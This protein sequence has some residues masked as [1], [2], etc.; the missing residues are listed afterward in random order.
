MILIEDGVLEHDGT[1]RW[2]TGPK[3]EAS[4]AILLAL[5]LPSAVNLTA[6]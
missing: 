1:Q 6:E 2:L 5:I 3:A 4:G